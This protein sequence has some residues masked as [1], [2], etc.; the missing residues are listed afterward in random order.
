VKKELFKC[1]CN[2]WFSEEK[3]FRKHI[4][5]F[6]SELTEDEQNDLLQT[7]K[8]IEASVSNNLTNENS[9]QEAGDRET[10]ISKYKRK[11]LKILYSLNISGKIIDSI[12]FCHDYNKVKRIV[13]NLNRETKR[14]L[15]LN[16][17]VIQPVK[18]KKKKKSSAN[19]KSTS[20]KSTEFFDQTL[21]SIKPIYT[22]MGNKR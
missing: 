17:V 14:R 4:Y 18:T 12:I 16:G 1:I 22:P 2:D 9:D 5:L 11:V 7:R 13:S 3:K 10:E 6:H 15:K 20:K 19:L 8:F 21:N